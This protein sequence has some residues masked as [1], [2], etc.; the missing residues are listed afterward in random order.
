[1]P[2]TESDSLKE[3]VMKVMI[4][5]A[6]ALNGKIS[7]EDREIIVDWMD[8]LQMEGPEKVRIKTLLTEEFDSI[9][10]SVFFNQLHAALSDREKKEGIKEI[11]DRILKDRKTIFKLEKKLQAKIQEMINDQSLIERLHKHSKN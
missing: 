9:Q 5:E 6:A 7:D 3:I 11:T 2:F 8:N 10:I 4:A 1:M